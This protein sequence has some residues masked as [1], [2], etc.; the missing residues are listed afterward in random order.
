MSFHCDS[1]EY[2]EIPL[3]DLRFDERVADMVE[4]RKGNFPDKLLNNIYSSGSFK[5]D[6][7]RLDRILEGYSTGLPP[8]QVVKEMSKYVVMNGRHRVCATILNGG[9]K[10]ACEIVERIVK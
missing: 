3:E 8:I 7:S 5:L 4:E 2:T 10:V 6:N 9:N 1:K